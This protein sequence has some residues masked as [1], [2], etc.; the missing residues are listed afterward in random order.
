MQH[1]KKIFKN[2]NCVYFMF[3]WNHNTSLSEMENLSQ[4]FRH[5]PFKIASRKNWMDN[6]AWKYETAFNAFTGAEA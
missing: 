1:F 6:E 5:F 4:I 3:L 2:Q